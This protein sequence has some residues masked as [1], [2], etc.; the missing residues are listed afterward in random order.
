MAT[1][2]LFIAANAETISCPELD[3]RDPDKPVKPDLCYVHDKSQPVKTILIHTCENY[4]KKGE[5][6][7]AGAVSCEFDLLSEKWAWVDEKTQ[8]WGSTGFETSSQV[9]NSE[10]NYKREKAYCRYVSDFLVNLNNGRSCGNPW[11]CHSMNCDN[12]VC[13]GLTYE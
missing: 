4:Q 8:H 1:A 7:M 6:T 5:T 11:E 2:A 10:L 12:G 9:S 3:C 13:K